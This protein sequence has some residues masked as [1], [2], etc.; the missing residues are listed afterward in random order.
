MV[1]G[2]PGAIIGGLLRGISAAGAA[3]ADPSDRQGGGQ[4]PID[5]SVRLIQMQATNTSYIAA[6]AELA[7]NVMAQ[8]AVAT[9][10][11]PP[12]TPLSDNLMAEIRGLREDVSQQTPYLNDISRYGRRTAEGVGDFA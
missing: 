4:L 2:L 1:G 10:T 3:E 5:D 8:A 9:L 6:A 12:A 7:R 11:P